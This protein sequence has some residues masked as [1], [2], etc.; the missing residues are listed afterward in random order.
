MKKLFLLCFVLLTHYGHSQTWENTKPDYSSL[1]GLLTV[2]DGVYTMSFQNGSYSH[3]TDIVSVILHTKEDV[4]LFYNDIE[5]ALLLTDKK[6]VRE[7]YSIS[8]DKQYI[9]IYDRNGVRSHPQPKKYIKP[10]KGFL[11]TKTEVLTYLN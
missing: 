4:I 1:G 5:S 10:G 8:T 6:I 3:I 11:G 2:K 7:G 9:Y